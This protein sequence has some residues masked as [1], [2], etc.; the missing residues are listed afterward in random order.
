MPCPTIFWFRRD[1]RIN[2]NAGLF[3]A[4]KSGSKVRCVFVFDTEILDQLAPSD[5]RMDFI[6]QSVFALRQELQQ[7]GSDLHVAHGKAR[8]IIPALAH[9]WSANTII[10]NR[11]YEPAALARDA[12]VAKQLQQQG[13]TLLLYK[14]QVIFETDEVLSVSHRPYT[15]FTPY[16]NAWLKKLNPFYLQSYPSQNYIQQLEHWQAPPSPTLEALGFAPANLPL[17]G[18]SQAAV[19]LFADFMPRVEHYKRWRDF[20]ATKGV[21]YLSVHLRFGTISIR[22]LAQFAWQQGGEGAE[23]WLGELIWRDFYQQLLWHFPFV[24]DRSFKEEYRELVFA[25]NEAWFAA[26]QQGRTGYPIVDAAMRQL[27]QSGYMHNRLRM[28]VAS[29][30]VKDLLIDWRWGEAYFAEKLMDFDLAANNGGWQW[31]ASTGCDAQPYFR[32]FNPVTQSEKFDPDGKFI[33]R[34]L[35]ELAQL[36][37][38]DIHAPWLA[39]SLPMGFQLGRDYPAPIVEHATQR[40]YALALFKKQ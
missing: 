23:C 18:G 21:S 35:P 2:D 10:A 39:K 15:V 37:I 34:Y 6:W 25:N 13:I 19:Q 29:F 31:A 24:V 16:K 26:W 8:H 38:K 1:L 11:D 12:E 33:R 4:L 36:T 17:Q 14:D 28:I 3:H 22:Q 32:I 9:E 27:N 40:Q 20:P 5:R 30:L 7:H